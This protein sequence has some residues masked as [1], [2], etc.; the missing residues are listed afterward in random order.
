MK[1]LRL[2]MDDLAGA[3]ADKTY[4]GKKVSVT[5]VGT[6]TIKLMLAC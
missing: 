3:L 5:G 2:T 6:N 4:E 1:A